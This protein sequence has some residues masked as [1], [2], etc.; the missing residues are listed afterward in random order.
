ME[1]IEQNCTITHEG[2]EFSAG[3]AVP[4]AIDN[5][6]VCISQQK[7][8]RYGLARQPSWN[9]TGTLPTEDCSTFP[10][11]QRRSSRHAVIAGR[12]Y[13][14]MLTISLLDEGSPMLFQ[15]ESNE[16]GSVQ[17]TSMSIRRQ[18]QIIR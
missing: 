12:H 14:T 18:V 5:Y 4:P 1:L 9:L 3:G 13:L 15:A 10:H 16:T 11:T 2:K 7:W 8:T 17:I 6:C